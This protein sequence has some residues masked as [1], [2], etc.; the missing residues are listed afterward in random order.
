M[1]RI[2]ILLLLLACAP[3]ARAQE[4]EAAPPSP[5]SPAGTA[6][7]PSPAPP[8]PAPALPAPLLPPAVPLVS[9]PATPAAPP[10]APPAAPPTASAG[11]QSTAP[12]ETPRV[13]GT[14]SSADDSAV[15]PEDDAAATEGE[16]IEMVDTIPPGSAYAL[17]KV[18]LERFESDDVHKILAA[19]PGVYIR[20]EDGYGLRPN[21]GM[22]GTGSE[23]SAKI[24]LMEDGV[25]IAPAPYSAPAAYYFPMVTRMQRVE[26]LKGPAA[27]RHGPN[28][29]GGAINLVTRPIPRAREIDVDLAGGSDLY[30]K[31]HLV[32]GDSTEHFG[33]LVEGVKLR[34]DGFKQLDG[35][36][37]TGFDK[38]GVMLKLR[39]SLDP[40][41]EVHHQLDL[42]LAYSDEVSDETY[43]GLTDEDFAANPYRRYR[44]TQLDR[45]DWRHY[46]VQ[47]AHTARFGAVDLV[48]TAYHHDLSRDWRKLDGFSGD[49]LLSQVLANP[50]TGNN[51]VRYAVLTGAEDS[52]PSNGAD[53]LLLGTNAR[54][55]VS[56]GVQLVAR[57]D[58]SWLGVL[59]SLEVGTRLHHDLADRDRYEDYFEMSAGNLVPAVNMDGEPLIGGAPVLDATDSTTAWASYYQ[60]R[61][62]IGDWQVTA[63]VR[64]ELIAARSENNMSGASIEEDQFIILPGG[65]VVWQALPSLGLLAGVHRGFVPVMPDPVYTSHPEQSINY[66][67][68]FRWLD[69]GANVEVIGFFNDYSN[70]S[71]ACTFSAGCSPDQMDRNFDGGKARSYGVESLVSAAPVIARDLSLPLRVGYTFQR[72]TFQSA[73]QSAH[74]Q[75]GEIAAG[76]ELPYLPAHQLQVQAGVAAAAWELTLSG[77]YVGAMRDI[78]SQDG[79]KPTSWT[80]SATVIDL[81]ASY[82]APAHWGKLY[83]TINNL[84]DE[85]HVTS[86][87]PY[88]ARPG[89]PRQI[90]FGYK[91][92]L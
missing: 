46:Q 86:R 65:G 82:Q 17:S 32:Y 29:V 55:F 28:T 81:A 85:A 33:W 11:S 22:R 15:L 24:A 35:G 54:D 50:D 84:L 70:L 58:Q 90:I 13:D 30:G 26:V 3:A 52:D 37:D 43:T 14:A 47:L 78:A 79:G 25:L 74:P 73:F 6:P 19:V 87:R 72:T 75:W 59:H 91:T 67:A 83:F 64:T 63:G 40:S 62:A 12:A 57:T 61:I 56:Q 10:P 68:G 27:I 16:V 60:H 4:S 39:A 53:D 66:E 51:A 31:A 20:E 18:E 34:T 88:G 1:K 80:D 41:A 92:S 44:G 5:P 48:T 42:K 36:G 23:R 8:A 69:L 76:D 45:M 71:S 77:R 9:P 2:A 89:V 7:A 38:N 49:A 21:I